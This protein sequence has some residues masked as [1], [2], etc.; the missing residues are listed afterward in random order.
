MQ[1][2]VVRHGDAT[3]GVPDFNRRLSVRGVKQVKHL[4][5]RLKNLHWQPDFIIHSGLVRAFET[6]Q[7]LSNYA[8]NGMEIRKVD[9]LTPEDSPQD[10]VYT[11]AEE[12]RNILMVSHMPLVF[13]FSQELIGRDKIIHYQ[14]STA[15]LFKRDLSNGSPWKMEWSLAPVH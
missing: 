14:T 8:F 12:R 5:E 11:F 4:A 13:D 15:V 7:I 10:L 6:A 1:L 3:G 9:G 2:L